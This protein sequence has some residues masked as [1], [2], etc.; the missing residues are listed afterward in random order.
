MNLKSVIA[1]AATVGILSSCGEDPAQ[2]PQ[3]ELQTPSTIPVQTVEWYLEH[4][5]ERDTMFKH[6]KNN[7]GELR[8][9]PNCLNAREAHRK[10]HHRAMIKISEENLKALSSGRQ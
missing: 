6:C 2:G 10:A 8:D 5:A 3:A 1:A 9:H 7:P 4:K